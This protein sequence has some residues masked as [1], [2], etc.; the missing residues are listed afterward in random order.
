MTE[1]WPTA[2][3]HGFAWLGVSAIFWAAAWAFARRNRR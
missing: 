2:I 1:T 3:D